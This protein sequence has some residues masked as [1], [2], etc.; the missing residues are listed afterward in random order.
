MFILAYSIDSHV[1]LPI[2]A[3]SRSLTDILQHL[4]L[5]WSIRSIPIHLSKTSTPTY[6]LPYRWA[7][8]NIV[9]AHHP[10]LAILQKIIHLRH[11]AST[12]DDVHHSL[13]TNR[14]FLWF[15]R[16]IDYSWSF[17]YHFVSPPPLLRVTPS[18]NRDNIYSI[19][20]VLPF[21]RRL[22]SNAS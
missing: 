20:L 17:V 11:I 10:F 19:S 21:H 9:T 18:Y 8:R 12:I 13:T 1:R 14:A 6:T 3:C 15:P 16:H 4:H 22:I 5:Y 7:T 2:D